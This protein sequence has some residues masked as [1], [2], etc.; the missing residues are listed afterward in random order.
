MLFIT[1]NQNKLAEA[2]KIIP[3]TTGKEIDIDEIQSFDHE[4]VIQA[5]TKAIAKQ[6]SEPF[7]C[8]DV[9]MNIEAINGLPGPFIKFYFKQLQVEGMYEL[10][11]HSPAVARASIGYFDG[12]IIHTF[13]GEVQGK[14]VEPRGNKDFG[15][16]ACFQPDGYDQTYGEMSKEVK[17]TISHRYLALK[18]LK[19]FLDQQ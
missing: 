18:Q 3:G 8:E 7:F 6:V 1:G 4:E 12:D 14:I 5:K 19:E 10:T 11:P 17:N 2:Q 9:S 13:H 16:D 15:F